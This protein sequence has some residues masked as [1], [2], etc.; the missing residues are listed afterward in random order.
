M[1]ANR[2]TARPGEAA[3]FESEKI[4]V[5]RMGKELMASYDAGG[6]YV[7]DAM[8]L[9]PKS[10]SNYSLKY[11]LALINSRLLGYFYQEF[12]ITID[13]LKNAILD[14]P[15]RAV[16]FSKPADKKAR[17]RTKSAQ[18]FACPAPLV[19]MMESNFSN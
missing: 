17:K 4:M 12:F 6:L 7:K 3:R 13:V 18:C 11:L 5:A 15:I 1:K 19:A 14:L 8:L 16:D 9:L 10:D 2:S